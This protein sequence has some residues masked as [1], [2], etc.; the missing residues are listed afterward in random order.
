MMQ[1]PTPNSTNPAIDARRAP[2]RSA[3]WPPSTMKA[4]E[5]IR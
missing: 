4:A 3:A 1:D 2:N 5:T